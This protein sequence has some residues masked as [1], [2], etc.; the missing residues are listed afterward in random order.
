VFRDISLVSHRVVSAANPLEIELQNRYTA[1]GINKTK[2]IASLV[3][4][5]MDG[6]GK[7]ERVVDRWDGKGLP[8]GFVGEVCLFFSLFSL[9]FSL[10]SRYLLCLR[11]EMLT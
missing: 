11:I 3:Q 5:F 10:R 7:I 4:V 2:E 6:D 9:V 8:E 1:K